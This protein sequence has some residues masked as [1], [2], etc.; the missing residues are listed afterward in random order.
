MNTTTN[1]A[2]NATTTMV[3][4]RPVTI[5]TIKDMKQ[6]GEPI[7]MI[8][9]YDVAMARNANE[10]GIDMILV[11]DSLGNVILG[12]QSTIPV[13]MNEMIHHTKAV[14]RGNSTALVVV[15][16]PFMSYQA[17]LTDGLYNAGR[18]LKETGCSAV[19]LE[20]GQAVCELVH[21]LT[22]AGIPVVAHIGLTPQSVNQLGGFKVQG[23]EV[24]AAQ[25]L[26]TDAK[27]LEAAGAFACV[28]ECVPAAL[29]KKITNELTTMATIGIGAGNDCDGQVLV[30]NDLLG[31]STGFTPKFV[32][33]YANLHDITV[34]AVKDYIKDVKER[35]FPAPEHTFTIDDSVLEKLY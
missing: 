2:T 23:K 26:L 30:C 15:D 27:A 22:T 14:V 35:S 17:S 28:L 5:T 13:T 12:Y 8:T 21:T 10:A 29:A 4:K 25:Q 18:L 9:A 32:K 6:K 11:G 1:A 33:Q 31:V 20:G 16:M 24:A 7:T 3:P 19:K 34:N